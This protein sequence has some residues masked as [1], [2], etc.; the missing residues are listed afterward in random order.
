MARSG[1]RNAAA[2]SLS[3]H[4][5]SGIAKRGGRSSMR[6]IMDMDRVWDLQV[7]WTRF[8]DASVLI[9]CSISVASIAAILI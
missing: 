1:R 5:G 7:N 9:V 8:F 2:A 6:G 4:S 3:P